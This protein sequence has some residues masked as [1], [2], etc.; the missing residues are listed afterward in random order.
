MDEAAER[1]IAEL[2]AKVAGLSAELEAQRSRTSRWVRGMAD[3]MPVMLSYVDRTGRFRFANKAYEDW[4][5]R[6]VGEIVDRHVSEVMPADAY[7]AREPYMARAFAGERVRY[8][9]AFPHPTGLR[10]TIID[11][12]PHAERGVVHGFYALVRDVTDERRALAVATESEQRFRRIADSA[13]VPIWVTAPD[14]TREFANKAYVEFLGVPYEAALRFDWRTILHEDDQARIVRESTAGEA[15][16]GRFTL[17]ARYRRADGEWRWIRSVSQPRFDGAGMPEGFI[18]VAEDV[19]ESRRAAET[20]EAH[21]ADLAARVDRRTRERDR[22]WDLSR[23]PIT[24]TDRDGVWR[25]ASPAWTA[26]LGWSLDRLI[27]RTGEWMTHPDDLEATRAK[28]EHAIAG[29]AVRNFTNRLR[30]A[31]GGYRWISWSAVPE[32]D[33][34]YCVA[35]DVT[36]E[37]ER[38]DAMRRIEET[39]RQSQKMEALGQLTGGVAHDFN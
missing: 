23:D 4:F 31:D 38:A 32:G 37:R 17:E 22:L 1:R 7:A 10:H 11:H 9:A 20:A 39:L 3:A 34:V 6:P 30:A 16:G 12:I 29:G 36:L 19:T 21:A 28:A 26:I 25:S 13:P 15:S 27:G 33:S 24:V 18:G 35:R 8:E 5:G 14:R 2:E